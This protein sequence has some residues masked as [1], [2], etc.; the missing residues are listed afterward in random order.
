M[1]ARQYTNKD[2]A[3]LAPPQSFGAWR[4]FF[5]LSQQEVTFRAKIKISISSVV[6]I[7]KNRQV[8]TWDVA[9]A[10]A[11]AL[12]VSPMDVL[13]PTKATRIVRPRKKEERPAA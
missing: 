10:L 8:P 12:G 11:D 2:G 6:N 1:T 9:V 4:E 13:W 7:E 3:K 5:G